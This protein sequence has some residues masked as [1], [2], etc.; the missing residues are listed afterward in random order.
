[1]EAQ[2]TILMLPA[3]ASSATYGPQGDNVEGAPLDGILV[4]AGH[5]GRQLRFVTKA[6]GDQAD[7]LQHAT[8][9]D[10]PQL[11]IETAGT[12]AFDGGG[13]SS[14][15]GTGG[16]AGGSYTRTVNALSVALH[17]AV[18]R[19]ALHRLAAGLADQAQQLAAAQALAV[20]A[21]AS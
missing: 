7:R 16:E 4:W 14:D 3:N 12:A 10:S 1:M 13:A 9:P 17:R 15:Q 20:V 18:E 5:I 8:G 21:P 19:V 6:A 2:R 11:T